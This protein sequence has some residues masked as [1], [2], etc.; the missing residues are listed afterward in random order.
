[1]KILMING[2]PHT[3]GTTAL[4]KDSFTEGALLAG[5]SVTYFDAAKEEL[6]PC[7]GCNHCRNT[8][9]GCVYKDAMEK[10]NPL[11]LDADCI[12]FIT[13]LYYFGMSAQIKMAIDRFYANNTLLRSQN[14]KAILLAACGDKDDWAMDA[15]TAHYKAVCHYLHWEDAGSILAYGMY[16]REDIENSDYPEKAKE[17][18]ASLA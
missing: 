13:P 18:G 10:L 4:L 6:H 11:L 15:L 1:M 14:K 7:L 12:V 5:H 8:E 16:V 3:H 9:D 2:S 17:L